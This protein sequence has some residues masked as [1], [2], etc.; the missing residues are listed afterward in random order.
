MCKQWI[1]GP[2]LSRLCGCLFC[3]VFVF[4]LGGE[5]GL[6]I[7]ISPDRGRQPPAFKLKFRISAQSC[8]MSWQLLWT[9]YNRLNHFSGHEGATY[10]ARGSYLLSQFGQDNQ[11]V[12]DVRLPGP[13]LPIK[14]YMVTSSKHYYRQVG[15]CLCPATTW[16][17]DAH[18]LS[19]FRLLYLMN[20]IVG[21][22]LHYIFWVLQRINVLV[23]CWISDGQSSLSTLHI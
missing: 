23:P 17:V 20:T 13:R 15:M 8:M 5:W 7:A 11:S 21:T 4:F 16:L 1:P 14:H 3:F 19:L 2:L 10:W 9:A 22:A 6:Y 12:T 18:Q